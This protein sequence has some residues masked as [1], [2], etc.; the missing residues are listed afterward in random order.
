MTFEKLGSVGR[1]C[2]HLDL[3]IVDEQG[4][5]VSPGEVGEIVLRGPKISKGYWKNPEATGK[6]FKDG[7]F[8]TG[9]MGRLDADGFLFIVDR[10]KDMIISGGE[11]IASLEVERVL[12]ELPTVLEASVIGVPNDR[13]GEVPKAFVVVKPGATLTA[14]EIQEH[15]MSRLAKFKVPKEV[16][17]IDKLPRNPSGKVLKR[18]LRE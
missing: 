2:L 5:E 14:E 16:E 1:P 11:N 18:L 3:K 12:Y 15:C 10:K 17:F 7:W 4:H 9:D 8:F 6:T 13:W